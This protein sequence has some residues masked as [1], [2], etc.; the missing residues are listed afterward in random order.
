MVFLDN[1]PGLG[2]SQ[3]NWGCQCVDARCVVKLPRI[4]LIT[5]A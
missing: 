5:H 1:P 3:S 4:Y 2:S